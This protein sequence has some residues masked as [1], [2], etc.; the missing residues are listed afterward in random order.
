MGLKFSYSDGGDLEGEGFVNEI[1]FVSLFVEV[2]F[3]FM[4]LECVLSLSCE[5][6]SVVYL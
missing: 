4:V 1:V 5:D 6:C 2:L 3:F